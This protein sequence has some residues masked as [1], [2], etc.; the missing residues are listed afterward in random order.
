[1]LYDLCILIPAIHLLLYLIADSSWARKKG[2]THRRHFVQNEYGVGVD[3]TILRRK[4][5]EAAKEQSAPR[6]KSVKQ[7]TA[8]PSRKGKAVFPSYKNMYI[9][10]YAAIRHSN[11]YENVPRDVQ[12]EDPNF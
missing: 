3:E 8:R 4:E 5:K 6:R 1:M 7:T 10:E 11:W 2:Y 9:I 12:I